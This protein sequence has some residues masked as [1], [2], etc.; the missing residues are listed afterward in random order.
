MRLKSDVVVSPIGCIKDGLECEWGMEGKI[1][2]WVKGGGKS[3]LK[4]MGVI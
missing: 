1:G 2:C 4:G 3:G